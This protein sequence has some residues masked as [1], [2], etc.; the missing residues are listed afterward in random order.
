MHIAD[1]VDMS[2]HAISDPAFANDC[3]ETLEATGVLVLEL[4]LI[5][6]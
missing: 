1:I 6:I 3:R 2:Q 5:H 4:S